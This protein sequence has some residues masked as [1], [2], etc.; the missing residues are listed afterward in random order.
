MSKRIKI[1]HERRDGNVDLDI[2][3]FPRKRNSINSQKRELLKYLDKEITYGSIDENNSRTTI[4]PVFYFFG[5]GSNDRVITFNLDRK[6]QERDPNLQSKDQKLN[7]SVGAKLR[8]Y[9]IQ[10]KELIQNN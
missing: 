8:R 5:S 9:I 4:N 3:Y 6:I 1:L 7:I 2:P 10:W